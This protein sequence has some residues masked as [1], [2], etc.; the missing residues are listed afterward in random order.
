MNECQLGLL[1]ESPDTPFNMQ[2]HSGH[3]EDQRACGVGGAGLGE[4]DHGADTVSQDRP[5]EEMPQRASF[6]LPGVSGSGGRWLYS[7]WP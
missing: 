4:L 7:V 6:C 1:F 3:C 5:G 2:R